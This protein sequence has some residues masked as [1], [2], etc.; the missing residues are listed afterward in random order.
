VPALYRAR[1]AFQPTATVVLFKPLTLTV[2]RESNAS[3]TKPPARN[4]SR[5]R[6]MIADLHYHQSMEGADS[7]QDFDA[8]CS[9]H[10]GHPRAQQRL[11]LHFAHRGR[12]LSVPP[13]QTHS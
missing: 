10:S 1:Q 11:R 2:G 12:P 9:L 8:D 5:R 4:R 6:G 3:R 7:Q 13:R